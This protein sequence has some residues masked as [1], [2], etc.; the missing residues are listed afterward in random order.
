MGDSPASRLS[1]PIVSEI[2]QKPCLS[3]KLYKEKNQR[4]SSNQR[5]TTVQGLLKPQKLAAALEPAKLETPRWGK[6]ENVLKQFP[7]FVCGGLKHEE[8]TTGERET[9]ESERWRRGRIG[10]ERCGQKRSNAM[11][12]RR[13]NGT[14]SSDAIVGGAK[15][16]E[17]T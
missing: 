5:Q 3:N 13:K 1:I 8:T 15:K 6:K 7:L 10:R 16:C 2:G 17:A 9:Q 4:G 12:K 11:Q 14:G